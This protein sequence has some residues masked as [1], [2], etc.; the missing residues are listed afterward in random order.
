MNDL[1]K[2]HN[3]TVNHKLQEEINSLRLD[4]DFRNITV[5][6]GPF[7]ALI[8]KLSGMYP[9]WTFEITNISNR[10]SY[11]PVVTEFTINEDK[12]YLGRVQREYH[13]A[14]MKMAIC[15]WRIDMSMTRGSNY[16][17]MDVDRAIAKIKKTFVRENAS[18]L[19]SNAREKAMNFVL[20]QIHNKAS[21]RR[22]LEMDLREKALTYAMGVGV[23]NFISSLPPAEQ[24]LL[25]E[26]FNS[27]KSLSSDLSFFAEVKDN[28]DTP[29]TNTV[30]V[31]VDSN[32]YIVKDYPVSEQVNIF[33]GDT[34][35]KNIAAS[36]GLLKLLGFEESMNG[37][38]CRVNET[39]FIVVSKEKQE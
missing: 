13:G 26:N 27:I 14:S 28:L 9:L 34:L 38:G 12:A 22:R 20:N 1:F 32:K 36:L 3:V 24:H 2:L 16:K 37:I 11:R 17:T 29:T 39:T 31:V 23:E 19:I 25:K 7:D 10:T 15:N 6:W 21:N 5:A 30:L 35:P 4:T 18:E 33:T 8:K